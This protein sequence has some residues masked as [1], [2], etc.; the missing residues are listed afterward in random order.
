MKKV[1]LLMTLGLKVTTLEIPQHYIRFCAYV[2]IINWSPIR[3]YPTKSK[4]KTKLPQ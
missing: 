2:V 1:P 4:G 3:K